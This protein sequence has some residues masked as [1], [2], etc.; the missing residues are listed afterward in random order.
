MILGAFSRLALAAL[1][2][3]SVFS[4]A[5]ALAGENGRLFYQM[6]ITN[7]GT[8]S[9]GWHGTLYDLSG[10]PV[11][12][13]PDALVQT[14]LG[15]FRNVPC[16]NLWDACGFIREGT[17]P[18]AAPSSMDALTDPVPWIYRLYIVAEGSKSEG[19]SGELVHGDKTIS[20]EGAKT[21]ETGMGRFIP[22]MAE[23]LWDW[24]GWAPEGWDK[25]K[26]N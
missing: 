3:I 12:A 9:Q 7:A 5:S 21:I 25:P 14:K 13:A 26:A 10:A 4:A 8:R 15:T 22:L 16:Q 11:K 23:H 17:L 19:L 6:E 20:S 2:A 1:A 24:A 18:Q